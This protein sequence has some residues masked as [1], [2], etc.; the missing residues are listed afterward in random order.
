[1][2]VE[3]R[4]SASGYAAALAAEKNYDNGQIYRIDGA[5]A[6]FETKAKIDLGLERCRDQIIDDYR[7]NFGRPSTVYGANGGE[8]SAEYRS[9]FNVNT[10]NQIIRA[11]YNA[12][13]INFRE[14]VL[15]DI[16]CRDFEF[17]N[18]IFDRKADAAFGITDRQQLMYQL[19]DHFDG[20]QTTGV[21]GHADDSVFDGSAWTRNDPR[22]I[23]VG[24]LYLTN[25]DPKALPRSDVSF[26]GGELLFPLLTDRDDREYRIRPEFG[27]I[28]Y[29][30]A[31]PLYLHAVTKITAGTRVVVT[32]WYNIPGY[33]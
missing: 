14:Q 7:N 6:L 22:R 12:L 23:M 25:Y 31:S 27:D 13:D 16:K 28:V 9:G 21:R 29:F 32:T 24:L 26:A 33:N 5:P 30:P 2:S 4:K 10:R 11:A 1:M 19:D 8:V 3:F 18:M 20:P 15:P 17:Y